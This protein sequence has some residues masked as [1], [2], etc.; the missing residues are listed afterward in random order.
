MGTHYQD[1]RM[2]LH[3]G[4]ALDVLATLPAESVNCVVTSPPY[5]KLR[6]YGH[7]GQYGNEPTVED[8]VSNMVAVFREARRVL[9]QDGT[10]W[11]NLGDSYGKGKQMLGVPWRVALGMQS[12]GWVLRNDIVWNKPNA[13]PEPVQDRLN[14]RHEHIFLFAKSLRYHFDL[15]PIRVPLV[16]PEAVAEGIVFGG[17]NKRQQGR[18]GASMRRT[19][20]TYK[21]G[22]GK[23]KNPGDVW[24][25]S[26]RKF[27]AA[28]FA[29]F[30]RDIPER[31]IMSGCKPGGTVLDIF[32]GSGTTGMVALE[33]G[34]PYVGID[35]S[36]EYLDLSLATRLRE[37]VLEVEA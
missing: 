5:Y 34:H 17:S 1:T 25:I 8:Y 15:D 28:H 31:A 21:A 3:H 12:D 36:A 33:L 37:H 2:T 7:D 29:T 6:D 10:L 4:K 9:A 19:G 32:H 30:P 27:P 22:A 16:R 20:S 14:A 11:L 18:V 24:Q 13:M 26:T 23:G 35:V